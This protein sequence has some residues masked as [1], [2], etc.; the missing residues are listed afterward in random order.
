[1]ITLGTAKINVNIKNQIAFTKAAR[2]ILNTDLEVYDPRRFIDPGCEV[3]KETVIEK[4]REF[5]SSDIAN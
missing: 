3:I 1:M 5:D 2:E 4:I